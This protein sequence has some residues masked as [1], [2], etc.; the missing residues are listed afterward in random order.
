MF[1]PTRGKRLPPE[2][3]ENDEVRRLIANCS[4]RAP[5]GIRNKAL[6]VAL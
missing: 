5:T 6:I 3:L 2:P 1:H 4:T